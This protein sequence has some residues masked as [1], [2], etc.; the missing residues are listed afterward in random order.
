MPRPAELL[1]GGAFLTM[2][3]IMRAGLVLAGLVLWSPAWA[4]G[5]AGAPA[6]PAAHIVYIDGSSQKI[7]QLTGDYDR[8]FGK[9]TTSQTAARFG[10]SAPDLGYSFEQHGSCSSCSMTRVRAP[11]P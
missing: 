3:V 11:K 4:V 9:P 7:Y 5:D 10:S 6:L 1:D 8:Q 2:R